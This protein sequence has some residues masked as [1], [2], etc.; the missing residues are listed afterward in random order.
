MPKFKDHMF[1]IDSK[2]KHTN[3]KLEQLLL[4]MLWSKLNHQHQQQLSTDGSE[5]PPSKI[6]I[7]HE[8]QHNPMSDSPSCE[9]IEEGICGGLS[10]DQME[11]E[12]TKGNW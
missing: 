5:A 3:E 7:A 2:V 9:M 10:I 4:S 1:S 6:P 12:R 11:L 8:D